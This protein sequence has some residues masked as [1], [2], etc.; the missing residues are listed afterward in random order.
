MRKSR[1]A[2]AAALILTLAL[3]GACGQPAGSESTDTEPIVVGTQKPTSLIPGNSR[4]F[5]ALSVAETLFSGLVRYDKETGEPQNLVAASIESEDQ[6]VWKIKLNEGWTFHNGEPV[7]AASFARG[8]NA[9]ADPDN[10]WLGSP[11]VA[12]I[13]G[14]DEVAPAE[15]EPTADELSGVEVDKEDGM[16]LTVTLSAPNSQFPYQLGQPAYYPLPE[17]ALD[18]LEGYAT[19]PIGNGPYK[20]IEP[21]T[22]GEEILTTRF[23]EYGGEVAKNAGVTFRVYSGYDVA[24]RDYQAGEVDITQLLPTDSA[25]AKNAYPDLFFDG[26][27]SN[28]MAYLSTPTYADGYNDPRIR[29]ALSMAIDRQEI[30]DALFK[31]PSYKPATDIGVPASIGYRED[32]CGAY[33]SFDPEAAKALW[34]EAGGVPGDLTLTVV[35][36]TG[37]D[38]YSEAIINGWEQHLGASVKLNFIPSE[39]T[40]ASLL[41]KETKNPASLSRNSD[42]PSPL[43]ILGAG[44]LTDAPSNYM[45]YSEPEFDKL[46][47]DAQAAPDAATSAELF[48]SAK[49]MLLKDMPIIPLWSSGANYVVSERVGESFVMDPYNKSPYSQ[50][51][52]G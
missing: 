50:I 26:E 38:A 43:A 12:Q 2:K 8:W 15:G 32:A 6:T 14:Y 47:A 52:V 34:D 36:G 25:A 4:G 1:L 23:E 3:L 21:W 20:L 24:Y 44:F 5:F 29:R 37:R 45:F 9:T 22:G 46:I 31:D 18:D 42:Y 39:N 16:A 35:T 30:I 10:A 28:A 27:V 49:N 41:G 13:D 33:C 48:D 11:F 19:H 17:A 51:A 40:H 7:D